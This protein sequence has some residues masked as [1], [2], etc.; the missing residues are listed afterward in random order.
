MVA[1]TYNVSPNTPERF[2]AGLSFSA[3]ASVIFIESAV[4]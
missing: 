1:E 2:A 3:A 4:I